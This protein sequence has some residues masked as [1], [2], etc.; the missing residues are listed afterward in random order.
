[1]RG[2]V[3]WLRPLPPPLLRNTSTC[4]EKSHARGHRPA[5]VGRN[6][7]TC[8]EKSHRLVRH[9]RRDAGNT[10]TCVEKSSKRSTSAAAL[11]ETPPHAWRSLNRLHYAELGYKKHLHM[12][13]EVP[14][15]LS[16]V[17]STPETPPHAW[18]SLSAF[19]ACGNAYGNTS[20]CV[21]KS[22]T[23]CGEISWHH[24]DAVEFDI[25]GGIRTI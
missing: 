23:S 12:R 25:L 9:G 19:R 5:C 18:R 13:G 11:T 2:E 14:K 10:S 17:L 8:V 16:F 20:T 22:A 1:M 7:S 4:V 21:E 24:Q 15:A 6:T 3:S